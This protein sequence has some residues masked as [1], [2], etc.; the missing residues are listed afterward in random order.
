VISI[1]PSRELPSSSAQVILLI[2]HEGTSYEEAATILDVPDRNTIRSRLSRGR[3][4]L[5]TL[6][7]EEMERG[8]ASGVAITSRAEAPTPRPGT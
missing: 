2:G 4:S 8:A 6:M 5:R 1:A 7:D 3:E